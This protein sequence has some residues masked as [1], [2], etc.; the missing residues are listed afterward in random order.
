LVLEV[1]EAPDLETV[2]L[3]RVYVPVAVYCFLEAP[4]PP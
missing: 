3:L 2:P 1:Y 4:G